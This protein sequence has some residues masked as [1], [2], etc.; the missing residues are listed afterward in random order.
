[1][2]K[3]GECVVKKKK[4]T[5][6]II[7]FLVVLLLIASAGAAAYEYKQI[8]QLNQTNS[9]LTAQIATNTKSVYVA[10]RYI[11]AGETVTDTGDGANVEIQNIASGVDATA[12]MMESEIGQVA[13]VDI[14][15]GYP[16]Y[17]NMVTETALTPDV[18]DVE[19]VEVLPMTIQSN[20]DAVDVRVK[21]PN[22]EDYLVLTNKTITDINLASCVFTIHMNE[23]EILR[24]QSACVDAYL[25]GGLLYTTKYVE[26]ALQTAEQELEPDY[27]VRAV[28]VDLISETDLNT[29]Y[30]SIVAATLNKQARRE[31]AERLGFDTQDNL[32]NE[33]GIKNDEAVTN[34]YLSEV[35]T[36]KS[37][38]ENRSQ[39][40]EDAAA[41]EYEEDTYTEDVADDEAQETEE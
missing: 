25:T 35:E 32:L 41:D 27:L 6:R 23:E 31:L 22:G 8:E 24:Y 17:Y 28:T 7:I 19:V 37:V 13:R 16:V 1:M 2:I 12:Y 11:K 33:E 26:P 39:T 21:F 18:R 10:T 38:L 20:Y 4:K 30:D 14:E 3:K 15:A 9:D 34:G 36:R 5:S 40:L 29:C